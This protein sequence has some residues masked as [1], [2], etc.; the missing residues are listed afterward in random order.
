MHIELHELRNEG[1]YLRKSKY[2][3]TLSAVCHRL[4][5]EL[6][7]KKGV[8]RGDIL[9]LAVRDMYKRDIG[10]YPAIGRADVMREQYPGV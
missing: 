7:C 2:T 9:E 3:F 1:N 10:D 4:I 6:T 5:N 8:Q